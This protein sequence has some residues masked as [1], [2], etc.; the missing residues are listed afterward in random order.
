MHKVLLT[1][2]FPWRKISPKHR[3]ALLSSQETKNGLV[4]TDFFLN[5]SIKSP[6]RVSYLAAEKD[7][8]RTFFN[9]TRALY[10]R[11]GVDLNPYFDLED[12]SISD[13]TKLFSCN[14]MHISGGNT[15]TLLHS[16]QKRGILREFYAYLEASNAIIGVS[17]GAMVLGHNIETAYLC[18]DLN[19]T[20]L[21]DYNAINAFPTSIRVHATE[22]DSLDS[23][24]NILTLSDDDA[25]VICDNTATSFGKPHFEPHLVKPLSK[26]N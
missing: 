21:T 12:A 15:F 4:A 5:Q 24:N 2:Q 18:G 23:E 6:A 22:D 14:V 9:R 17:A 13:I 20:G 25:V 19:E 16:M 11:L 1:T 3:F 10:H 26:V 8:S 7:A